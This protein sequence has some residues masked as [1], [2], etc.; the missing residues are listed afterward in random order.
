VFTELSLPGYQT[1]DVLGRGG[2]AVVHR[3]RQAT[4]DREVAIK[5]DGRVIL[6]ER[7]QKRF[8]REV[9][10]AGRLS[11]H[12]HVVEIYDAGVLPD[13]RPYLV[14]ELCPNGSLRGPLPV[15]DVVR[16]GA[17]IADALVAAH[18]LGVLHRDIKPG[19]I[20]LKR[21]GTPALADF[22]LAALIDPGRDSSVTLAALTPAYAPPE[23]F[24]H[25]PPTPRSDIYSLAATLYALISGRPPRFPDGHQPSLPE[26]V[27]YHDEPVPDLPG[28]PP[29]VTEVLRRGMAPDPAHRYPDAASF[30]AALTR[31]AERQLPH[32]VSANLTTAPVQQY[33]SVLP[34]QSTPS[35]STQDKPKRGKLLAALAIGVAAVLVLLGVWFVVNRDA[36]GT[37]GTPVA[38][39]GGG[40][41]PTLGTAP[42]LTTQFGQQTTTEGCPA[43]SVPGASARCT[44]RAECWSGMVVIEGEVT[45]IRRLDC[46]AEHVFETFAI[47]QVPANLATDY[48]DVLEADR[49]VKQVCSQKT[50]L[51]S[52]FGDATKYQDWDLEVLPPTPDDR[53][54]GRR[55][56]RCLARPEG[57]SVSGSA[58]RPRG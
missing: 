34:R 3:A 58:F 43:A 5:V 38:G 27:R 44:Q 12:P 46:G 8:L 53:T 25:D 56:Y 17:Q 45:N 48:M 51:A 16:I 20:L 32:S 30:R 28:V 37:P 41:S 23:A 47:A 22:G 11:G 50:L 57:H 15:A 26:I 35:Q 13:G 24:R 19:N 54:A 33:Q 4:I 39:N 55:V 7:D 31:L 21:Y 18:D 42:D 29:E 36:T 2:F 1:I 9:R 40:S 49:A 6:D 52:R 14:M 10:A